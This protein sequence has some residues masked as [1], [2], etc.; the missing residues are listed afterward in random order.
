MR[1]I[2]FSTILGLLFVASTT[3]AAD[4]KT[5]FQSKGCASCHN[6]TADTVGPS[7][8]KIAAAYKGKEDKLIEFLKGH[9]K[10][11]VDPAKFPIMMP[12]LNTTKKLSD[13]ELKALAD[14]I[15]SH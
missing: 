8:K 1:K 5:I 10:A 7:L 4:G 12:Q 9:G 2:F 15:L 3:F 14:F 11:I 6:P 13:E